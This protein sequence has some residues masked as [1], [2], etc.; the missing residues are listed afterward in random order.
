MSLRTLRALAVNIANTPIS[1]EL[2]AGLTSVRVKQSLSLPSQCEVTFALPSSS[3]NS[4][5]WTIGAALQVEVGSASLFSGEITAVEIVQDSSRVTKLCLRGYDVLHRLR[6]RKT[7]LALDPGKLEDLASE[8]VRDL[9]LTIQ[10]QSPTPALPYTAHGR[11][12][13]WE[14]LSSCSERCGYYFYLAGRELGLMTLAGRG[15]PIELK[16][17]ESLLE[18]AVELN[19]EHACDNVAVTG[20]DVEL[21]KLVFG[22]AARART[23]RGSNFRPADAGGLP[24]LGQHGLAVT[25]GSQVA[26]IAQAELDRRVASELTYRGCAVGNVHLTP[27]TRVRLDTAHPLA[28]EALALTHV[29]H[30]YDPE[31]GYLSEFGTDAPSL[32]SDSAAPVMVIGQVSRA[33]DPER[34]G[35]V[36]V[37]VASLG[38]IETG[39]LQVV[40]PAAGRARGLTAVPDEDDLVFVCFPSGDLARGLVLGGI[41]GPLGVADPA[42]TK[43]TSRLSLRS[44]TGHLLRLDDDAQKLTLTDAAGSVVEMGATGM[45]LHAAVPL[46]IEAPGQPIV[47][48]GKSIDFEQA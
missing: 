14:W 38:N 20:W 11:G 29:I 8:L 42:D 17:G 25:T 39:W 48:R 41:Y 35:R 18:V 24:S 16:L 22:E 10:T 9:G 47:I 40:V 6:K 23:P 44:K 36:R 28:S 46:V 1:Q 31:R 13:D 30:T 27:G 4:P 7:F 2:A 19:S 32:R 5:K 33:Q 43:A 26:D 21:G 15:E 34:L 37:R 45:S 12:N 3:S